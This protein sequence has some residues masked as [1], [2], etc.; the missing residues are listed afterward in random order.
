MVSF[1]KKNIK[2]KFLLKLIIQNILSFQQVNLIVNKL[3]EIN[4]KAAYKKGIKL[5][6]DIKNINKELT[7]K[8]HFN[9]CIVNYMLFI[10]TYSVAIGKPSTSSLSCSLHFYQS[11]FSLHGSFFPCL[12]TISL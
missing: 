11:R 1:G 3:K 2:L 5:K 6:F 10:N 12:Y 7:Y 4:L 9:I 8:M